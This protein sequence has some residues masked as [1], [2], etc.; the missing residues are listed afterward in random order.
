M[1]AHLG[2]RP[3]RNLYLR[4]TLTEF[5]SNA[6]LHHEP[7]PRYSGCKERA[8]EPLEQVDGW[9]VG[10]VSHLTIYAELVS[11][12]DVIRRALKSLPD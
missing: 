2:P 7:R 4:A 6:S 9:A 3:S 1:L 5:H 10:S 12:V 11:D 8:L